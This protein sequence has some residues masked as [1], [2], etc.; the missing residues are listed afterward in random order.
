MARKRDTYA[1]I[2]A[3]VLAEANRRN[4]VKETAH[5]VKEWW[6]HVEAPVDTAEYA[7]SIKL[8]K[9]PPHNG[10]PHYRVSTKHWRAHFIE[11][12]TGPDSHGGVRFI[13]RLGRTVGENTPTP[14]Y[15]P[16]AKTAHHFGGTTGP[17]KGLSSITH[18]LAE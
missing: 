12:G 10:L 14:E 17:V 7:A 4:E 5:K 11:Y 15:A 6:Q 13:P 3:K 1:E 2:E 8:K 9:M 18:E 16:A